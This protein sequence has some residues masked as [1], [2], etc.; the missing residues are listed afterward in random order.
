MKEQGK[1]SRSQRRS[2]KPPE[3]AGSLL[4]TSISGILNINKP[5]GMTSH[6]VVQCIRRTAGQRRVGHAGTLDPMATGV[7]L[8]CLGKA[9]RVAEYLTN[10]RKRYRARAVLGVTT[11]TYDQEGKITSQNPCPDLKADDLEAILQ[12]FTGHIQQIPPMYSAV[13]VG[14][15][16]LYH[17]AR[18]GVSVERKARSVEIHDIRL[19]DWSPPELFFEVECSKGTYIRSLAHDLGQS[20]GCGAYLVELVRLSSGAF[21]LEDAVSL[22]VAESSFTNGSWR[23]LLH[24]LDAA[25][26]AFQAVTLGWDEA[27]LVGHGRQIRLPKGIEGRLCRAYDPE[28]D[29]VALLRPGDE[30]EVWRPHKVFRPVPSPA[31][32]DAGQGMSGS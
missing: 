17:L 26:L 25:L 30:P 28:G 31:R 22:E 6:D 20:L 18:R 4:K 2:S 1:E 24:P 32:D 5:S 21:R 16:P 8:V 27:R 12:Q 23:Q 29:L 14:G 15:R 11:D 3:P 7:L 13:K 19:L 10:S 9:T